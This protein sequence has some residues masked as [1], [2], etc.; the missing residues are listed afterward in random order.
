MNL[1]ASSQTIE[2]RPYVSVKP[3]IRVEGY[4]EVEVLEEQAY[5]CWDMGLG[6]AAQDEGA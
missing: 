3:P 6:L 5:T 1:V 4:F 2:S